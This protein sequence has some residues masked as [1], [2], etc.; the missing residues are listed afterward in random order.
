ME[1]NKIIDLWIEY[2]RLE[3]LQKI[4]VDI[5]K[6]SPLQYVKSE[7]IEFI[8]DENNQEKIKIKL[9]DSADQISLENF[10]NLFIYNKKHHN[11]YANKE[12]NNTE[13]NNCENEILSEDAGVDYIYFLYPLLNIKEDSDNQWKHNAYITSLFALRIYKS[14]I[15]YN[16]TEKTAVIDINN[17][18]FIPLTENICKIFKI[19]QS[20]VDKDY[21]PANTTPIGAINNIS[22]L[23]GKSDIN[24]TKQNNLIENLLSAL[25]NYAKD[26]KEYTINKESFGCFVKNEDFNKNEFNKNIEIEMELL[27]KANVQEKSL[28]YKYL[29]NISEYDKGKAIDSET[30]WYGF[31]NKHDGKIYPLSAGQAS[32]LQKI[33]KNEELIAVHG[34]PGT[35]KTT[36]LISIIANR[37]VKR[38]IDI[39]NGGD[40]NNLMMIVSGSN[41]AV[42]NV[43]EK[44]QENFVN[45]DWLYY[46]GGAQKKINSEN[47]RLER[48][49]AQITKEVFDESKYDKLKKTITVIKNKLDEEYNVYKK[50]SKDI[51]LENAELEKLKKELRKEIDTQL[52]YIKSLENEDKK[53]NNLKERIENLFNLN[54][55]KY[56]NKESLIK[57]L[58]E[59]R[60]SRIAF[61]NASKNISGLRNDT[62]FLNDLKTNIET[63][64]S[65][66]TK[67]KTDI[68]HI[69]FLKKMLFKSHIRK[70][71]QFKLEFQYELERF[72]IFDAI[73]ENDEDSLF[74]AIN[75]CKILDDSMKTLCRHYPVHYKSEE[76][77]RYYEN[78]V[79]L[80]N[81]FYDGFGNLENI[82]TEIK[83]LN[84]T[85]RDLEIKS[86]KIEAKLSELKNKYEENYKSG[87]TEYYRTNEKILNLN[88]ELFELSVEFIKEHII[89]EKDKVEKALKDWKELLTKYNVNIISKYRGKIDEFAKLIS[90][91]YPV[92]A[93]TINSVFNLFRFPVS[94]I[95]RPFINLVLS[96]ESGMTPVHKIFPLIYR[97][98]MAVVIGDPKQIE[99]IMTLS[100]GQVKQYNDKFENNTEDME[101][102][103]PVT[104]SAYHRSAGCKT[105]SYDDIGDGI[106]LDE[107][108]RC[109]PII[110]NAFKS[111]AGYDGLSVKTQNINKNDAFYSIL[112][113]IGG[114]NLIFYDVN[115]KRGLSPN[116]NI[117][118]ILVIK[119]VIKKL[120]ECGLDTLRFDS[121]GIIT[122]YNAQEYFI[123]QEIKSDIEINKIFKYEEKDNKGHL[124]TRVGTIHKFQGT[125]FDAVILSPVIFEPD[126][127]SQFI[128]KKP[129]MLNV[130]ISRAKKIFIIVGNYSKLKN[131][132]GY[133]SFLTNY[134]EENGYI[135]ENPIYDF[136][137][138]KNNKYKSYDNN[139]IIDS[140]CKHIEIFNEFILNAKKEIV[141]V[142]PWIRGEEQYDI[143]KKAVKNGV[144]VKIIYGYGYN[145]ESS[146]FINDNNNDQS[147][148][149][150]YKQLIGNGLIRKNNGTH[151]KV[152]VQDMEKMVLGSFNWLSHNYYKYCK[153]ADYN[154]IDKALIRR[155]TSFILS[156]KNEVERYINNLN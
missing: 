33:K 29:H 146:E 125:E 47:E 130:A 61:S 131:A 28:A 74:S 142:S 58:Y 102:F 145:K 66:L 121:L 39:I 2:I 88:Q 24:E 115:G 57:L 19:E 86:E 30:Y 11:Y 82:K 117:N 87:F 72:N 55:S 114:K 135:I 153:Y 79:K 119:E 83:K 21:I 15:K 127:S 94:M 128:N 95:D 42:E 51:E 50:I 43:V 67:T 6:I 76:M 120:N 8:L 32:I 5:G 77:C 22:K 81:E 49:I 152:V 78:H 3:N 73:K 20:E 136:K 118:E 64:Y 25:K 10:L 9:P 104:V 107:H 150:K 137:D 110:A 111:L 75:T 101:R 108:R 156:D 23:I 112:E 4:R 41:K 93:T 91:A 129:N 70:I 71:R 123:K 63:F 62:E 139:T 37:I 133:L 103:S 53:L 116:T 154:K 13:I 48:F 151:E 140:T 35:G 27:K 56:E 124:K 60:L 65:C 155:E 18:N 85:I 26:L 149:E 97:T 143:I 126:D 69:H 31:S 84:E 98:D 54:I 106:M 105:G 148:V 14:N 92:T 44:L 134:I 113:K 16:E 38:T 80:I 12:K 122:P 17:A 45:Y 68:E 89:K 144:K 36:L 90:L 1:K 100:D 7:N 141:I 132:G 34:A 96:D 40:Y 138:G 109:A 99:P 52:N 59:D 147:L 46:S